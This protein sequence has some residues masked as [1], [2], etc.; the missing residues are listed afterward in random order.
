MSSLISSIKAFS[1]DSQKV[2]FQLLMTSNYCQNFSQETKKLTEQEL[3]ELFNE[4]E[5]LNE[6]GT[7]EAQIKALKKYELALEE[8]KVL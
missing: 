7:A 4:A 5:K 6:E 1:L 8:F 2:E 3:N